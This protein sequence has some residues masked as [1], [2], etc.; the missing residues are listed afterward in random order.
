MKKEIDKSVVD[1]YY[2]SIL[3]QNAINIQYGI[4]ERMFDA[5]DKARS[6]AKL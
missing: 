5:N 2:H 1:P 4:K 6:K 3:I